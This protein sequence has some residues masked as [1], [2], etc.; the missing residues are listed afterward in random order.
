MPTV[1]LLEQWVDWSVIHSGFT[2]VLAEMSL[3]VT[4]SGALNQMP[5]QLDMRVHLSGF[6]SHFYLFSNLKFVFIVYFSF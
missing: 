5:H 3:G 2:D 6:V 4:M 1:W